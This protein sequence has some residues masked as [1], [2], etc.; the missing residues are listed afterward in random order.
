M[1][2]LRLLIVPVSTAWS[3]GGDSSRAGRVHPI[4]N[5]GGERR[6]PL[7]LNQ[8]RGHPFP[9]AR[10]RHREI[11]HST[12]TAPQHQPDVGVY[13]LGSVAPPSS[14]WR[15]SGF[16]PGS[17]PSTDWESLLYWLLLSMTLDAHRGWS[18][19]SPIPRTAP[20][21]QDRSFFRSKRQVLGASGNSES[22]IRL[23]SDA[24]PSDRR[25]HG[26]IRSGDGA[27]M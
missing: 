3:A 6:R 2:G 23:R 5:E 25:E 24:V 14:P 19:Y 15:S 13:G 9:L 12:L 17:S 27:L 16:E 18:G 21:E 22:E 10:T 11:R 26:L 1:R 8:L 20:V 4:R 7:V